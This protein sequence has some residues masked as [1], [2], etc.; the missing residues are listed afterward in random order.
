MFWK[1][2]DFI[3]C[4]HIDK[5]NDINGQLYE[6]YSDNFDNLNMAV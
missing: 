5:I 3:N 4:Q 6:R 2:A 1:Q